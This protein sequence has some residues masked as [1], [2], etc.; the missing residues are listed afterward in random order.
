MKY[1]MIYI[2]VFIV[3]PVAF[4][5]PFHIRKKNEYTEILNKNDTYVLRGFAAVAVMIAHYVVYSMAEAGDLRGLISVW[6]WAGG[7]G[8]CI[9]F[10]CSG[11]GLLLST[12]NKEIN[13]QFL[14]KRLKSILPTY[15]L[16]RLMSAL[17]L[18]EMKNGVWDFILYVVGIKRPAW[19][20]TEILLVYLLFYISVKV[21]KKKEI[22]VMTVMLTVMSFF[23]FLLGFEAMWYNANLLFAL[24]MIFARYKESCIHWFCEKYFLKMVVVF[25]LFCLLA[26]IFVT[27][28]INGI[29]CDGIKLL[30][31]GGVCIILFQVLIKLKLE[32]VSMIFIGRNSLQ[33]YLIHSN[34]WAFCSQ[35]NVF[36]NVQLKFCICVAM[37][38]LCVWLYDVGRRM[39]KNFA[40]K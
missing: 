13:K 19:F 34:I 31:G 40:C 1:I 25:F 11:Y 37:S 24:G 39:I 38:L 35:G 20:V 4:F 9:F 26:G 28:K 14:W 32:S 2:L 33:L 17:L 6:K 8:V 5:F 15:W 7:L 12:A 10:F 21:S 27:L 16:L 22:L 23:F 3:F 36:V 18:N 30:A 29:S